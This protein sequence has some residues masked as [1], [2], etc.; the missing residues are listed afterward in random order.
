[1]REAFVEEADGPREMHDRGGGTGREEP[2]IAGPDRGGDSP[3]R[4]NTEITKQRQR[5][6]RLERCQKQ[7]SD[8]REKNQVPAK[9]GAREGEAN[10]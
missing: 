5:E 2:R 4:A 1:M 10:E 9:G 3:S 7:P 8:R 6:G